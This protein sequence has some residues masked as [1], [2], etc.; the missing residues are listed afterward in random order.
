MCT[1]RVAIRGLAR[2]WAGGAG[3]SQPIAKPG[4]AQRYVDAVALFPRRSQAKPEPARWT[5]AR[6]PALGRAELPRC[7]RQPANRISPI[8]HVE[9]PRALAG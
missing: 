5:R 4:T 3:I 9:Q 8:S 6:E 1:V 7:I 2:S